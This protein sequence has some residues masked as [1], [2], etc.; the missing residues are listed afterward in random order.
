MFLISRFRCLFSF[1]SDDKGSLN[2][3][4]EAIRTNYNDRYDELRKRW[5]GGILGPK[6]QAAKNKLEKTK[7]KEQLSKIA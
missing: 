3:L 2:K 7:Q 5:G 4:L 1:C 6:A